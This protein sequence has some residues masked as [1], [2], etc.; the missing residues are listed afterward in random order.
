MPTW[1]YPVLEGVIAFFLV[2]GGLFAFIGSLGL[3]H[4]KDFYMR[5]HGPSKTTTL[6]VGCVL[7]ASMIYFRATT[8]HFSF[9]EMLVSIFLFITAP[10]TA[11]LLSKAALHQKLVADSRTRN[12]PERLEVAEEP[13]EVNAESSESR[14]P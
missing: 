12:V 7:M 6:G 8:G 3:T 14:L 10:V 11:H 9:Q 13:D 1:F 4:L 5:L 2:A